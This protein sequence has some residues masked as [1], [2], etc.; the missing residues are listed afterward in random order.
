MFH[1]TTPANLCLWCKRKKILRT[2]QGGYV[3]LV[4]VLTPNSIGWGVI[5]LGCTQYFTTRMTINKHVISWP[6]D[7]YYEQALGNLL[8]R[9]NNVQGRTKSRKAG[10]ENLLH[11]VPPPYIPICCHSSWEKRSEQLT[12]GRWGSCADL[13]KKGSYWAGDAISSMKLYVSY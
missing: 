3:G 2:C 9:W 7:H 8:T 4:L 10:F 6:Y 1:N 5:S 13:V 11:K 12:Q